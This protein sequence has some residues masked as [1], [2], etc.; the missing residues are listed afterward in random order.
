MHHALSASVPAALPA[1]R[2]TRDTWPTSVDTGHIE[3]CWANSEE[4]VR[5]VRRLRYRVFV[6]EM[7][8]RM[9]P[10][11]SLSGLDIDY[12]DAFCDH[13]LVRARDTERDG[14]YKLVGTYRVLSPT[15]AARAGGFYTDTEFDL[16][17]L[18]RLRPR[19]VEL[20]RACVHPAW[21]SGGV[22]MA[23]WSAL[24]HYMITHRLD[25]M[26]GCASVRLNDGGQNANTLWRH[27]RST[28]MAA[29]KWQ[30]R[31]RIALPLEPEK[32]TS[33]TLSSKA[34]TPP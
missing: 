30:V 4:D 7:G 28:H 3:V 1:L 25:T 18:S 26:I 23:L 22:I 21:R 12:F 27:L 11:A 17:P 29:R 20:D 19:A 10:S 33:I 8:A 14:R 9:T 13:L 15:A 5:E 31:P 6:Q 34:V 2:Q 16:T 32:S 24:G